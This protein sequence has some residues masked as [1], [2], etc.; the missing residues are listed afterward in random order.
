MLLPSGIRRIAFFVVI[1][2]LATFA[3]IAT[4]NAS[5]SSTV[6][7]VSGECTVL[8]EPSGDRFVYEKN[9]HARR[10]MASTTKIMTALVVLENA[11]LDDTVTVTAESVGIEGTSASL[12]AEDRISVHDLLYLMMLESANDAASALAIHVGGSIEGFAEMMN[13]RARSLGMSD[14]NFTNPHGLSSDEHYTSAADMA[15]LAAEALKNDTFAKI[16]STKSITLQLQGGKTSFTA[17]N[18]NKLLRMYDGA[19][20]VKTGFTKKSGRCLVGAAERDGVRLICV[21]LNASDDWNDHM[22]LLDYGFELFE[23]VSLASPGDFSYTLPV[24]D[25]IDERVECVNAVG[26]SLVMPKKRDEIEVSVNLSRFLV[27]PI[28]RGQEVGR[29]SFRYEGDIIAQIPIIASK[30]IFS[31]TRADD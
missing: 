15:V 9:S 11:S 23:N 26:A 2:L 14:S 21:T 16:V 30:S 3:F 8:Y 5:S 19:I 31:L 10:P 18:H 1:S 22:R 28:E 17:G 12:T 4:V 25:G 24:I 7:S 27:A 29:V 13:A 6:P 20:G